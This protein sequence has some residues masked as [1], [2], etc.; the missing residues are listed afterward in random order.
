MKPAVAAVAVAEVVEV[1]PV[2]VALAVALIGLES[3]LA[4]IVEVVLGWLF[5]Y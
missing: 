4:K 5:F 1:A 3:G 2:A